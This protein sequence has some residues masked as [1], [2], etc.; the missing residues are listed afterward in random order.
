M[1]ESRF[2]IRRQFAETL[3]QQ[4]LDQA[5]KHFWAVYGA[6]GV[7]KSHLLEVWYRKAKATGLPAL[8]ISAEAE[9]PSPE[10]WFLQAEHANAPYFLQVKNAPEPFSDTATGANKAMKHA[11]RSDESH[12]EL[13]LIRGF[14]D[15]ASSSGQGILLLDT[16]KATP[17]MFVHSAV[18][19]FS[20]QTEAHVSP[21]P[22]AFEDFMKHLSTYAGKAGNLKIVIAGR[23]LQYLLRQFD[24]EGLRITR[25]HGF[26]PG[27]IR[28]Y[29]R[30]QTASE[31]SDEHLVQLETLTKGNPLLLQSF[32][33]RMKSD[34]ANSWDWAQFPAFA[35]DFRKNGENGLRR[36][37]T[38]HIVDNSRELEGMWKLAVPLSIPEEIVPILYPAPNNTEGKAFACDTF[39]RYQQKGV[40]YTDE[41]GNRKL[42]PEIREA[43][44]CWMEQEFGSQK[45]FFMDDD[46]LLDLHTRLRNFY[47]E[48]ADWPD[49]YGNEFEEVFK[50]LL[51]NYHPA[52]VHAS[53]HAFGAIP[54]FERDY[55]Q[56]EYNRL[57][58]RQLFHESPAGTDALARWIVDHLGDNQ[59]F[60][61]DLIARFTAEK[62]YYGAAFWQY[63]QK[64]RDAASAPF[65]Y[66]E[67]EAFT[68]K[69]LQQF[70]EEPV[71]LNTKGKFYADREEYALAKEFF[72]KAVKHMPGFPLAWNNLGLA[73]YSQGNFAKA[74]EAWEIYAEISP[75]DPE[76]WANL[77]LA[78][79]KYGNFSKARLYFQKAAAINEGKEED[80]RESPTLNETQQEAEDFYHKALQQGVAM[81]EALLLK[82][83]VYFDH[84]WTKQAIEAWQQ[85]VSQKP[86]YG[87]AWHKLGNARE[88]L[89]HYEQAIDAYQHA[90]EI[91]QDPDLLSDLGW[92]YFTLLQKDRAKTCFLQELEI[93]EEPHA[94]MNLGHIILIEGKREEAVAYYKNSIETF[95]DNTG[96][97]AGFQEDWHYMQQYG[98]DENAY[99]QVF[100]TLKAQYG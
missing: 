25:L 84:D 91:A 2:F 11:A 67:D 68:D 46:R 80:R 52:L 54:Y 77:G 90:L 8:L 38:Q 47:D 29:A 43:L 51:H 28:E 74:I 85:A 75:D 20:A 9:E 86:D 16:G 57:Q 82:G 7:G 92:L 31:P 59:D 34:A 56:A 19:A 49:A 3:W 4:L 55:Q 44:W 98:V 27:E 40:L 6:P 66:E 15:D 22:L 13:A 95:P 26:D 14:M 23:S 18:N 5:N 32:F 78:F 64:H 35:E 69:A 89:G 79:N 39:A 24:A 60:M 83:Q 88:T 58:V 96:F 53:Y 70:P 63:L 41:S 42:Y 37:L 61:Q 73:N 87:V 81:H 33:T 36:Y 17:D 48:Q 97:F 65:F 10:Q 21:E 100:Q 99:W 30:K 76:A 93:H 1:N 45:H 12:K 71:L 72:Q 50:R 62:A 94:L